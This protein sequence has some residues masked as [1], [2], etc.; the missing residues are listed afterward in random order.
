MKKSFLVYPFVIAILPALALYAYNAQELSLSIVLVP[1]GI[2]LAFALLL[3]FPAWLI[4]RNVNKAGIILSLFLVLLFSTGHVFTL[5]RWLG[6]SG[7]YA[8][9]A[10]L[11]LIW[12]LLFPCLVYLILR[13]SKTLRYPTIILNVVAIFLLLSCS[14][15]IGV[16]EVKRLALAQ[17][18]LGSETA[19]QLDPEGIQELPDIYY[20]VLD[21]YAS[22]TTL[23][24]DYDYD[25]SE[26]VDYLAD[27]GFY[28]ASESTANYVRTL[29]SLASSLNM[30]YLDYMDE[31]SSDLLP[32]N[33]K[34][35]DH[36]VQRTLK[37][38][39]YTF[40]HVGSWWGPTRE[41]SF[42]DVNINYNAEISEFSESLLSN[43]MPYSVCTELGLI[44][45]KYTS[46]WK[47]T[48]F[49]FEQMAEIAQMEEPT[50][51]VAHMLVPHL[52]Y[53]F[54][55]DGSFLPPEEAIERSDRDNYVNQLIAT[56]T[57][58]TGLIDQLLS[59]SGVPPIIVLQADEGP[60]P[61]RYMADH[62]NFNWEEAT[63]EELRKK[64]GILNAYYLPGVD[65]SALYQS[66][67]P[68]NSF[69]LVFDLYFD[70][71]LGL[72]DDASYVYQ[73]YYHPYKF[74]DVT[75]K[76]KYD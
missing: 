48:L 17:D 36:A 19:V 61:D 30:E 44:E 55:S 65:S 66:I 73:D 32:L 25:N 24:E 8:G 51:V 62:R 56:N 2:A 29:Q 76:V 26:F 37:S 58:V 42:A 21:R 20:I 63:D 47:R 33:L 11:F 39:G 12:A 3:F 18:S 9:A 68:V 53:V 10:L 43:V 40:V 15:R 46:Q 75:D 1:L 64:M 13:T 14:V 70:A 38:A 50:F 41:N 28:V 54:D 22:A 57:M 7:P 45:D 5:T 72:L 71:G 16:N 35:E 74:L 67:T 31:E 69:R 27:K 49:E 4:C 59:D 34:L 60:Y 52:P 6:I 23:T